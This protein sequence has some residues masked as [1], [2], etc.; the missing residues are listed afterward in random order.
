MKMTCMRCGGSGHYSFNLIR[1]TVCFGCDGVGQVVVS[2]AKVKKQKESAE[3]LKEKAKHCVPCWNGNHAKC[4]SP[5]CK[6]A[7]CH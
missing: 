7:T 1:G 5:D 6:C 2:A 4:A 3:I